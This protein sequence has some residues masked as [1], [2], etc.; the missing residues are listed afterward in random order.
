MCIRDRIAREH[1]VAVVVADTAGRYPLL[2]EV[3]TDFV[4]V[5]LHGNE[6]VAYTHLRAHETQRRISYYR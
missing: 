5:R 3:T 6:A 1:G 4:Y 2:R